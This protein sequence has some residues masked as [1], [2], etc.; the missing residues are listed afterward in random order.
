MKNIILLFVLISGFLNCKPQDLNNYEFSKKKD[1]FGSIEN[2]LICDYVCEYFVEHNYFPKSKNEYEKFVIE[3]Q[4]DEKI[5][6]LLKD[7]NYHF[8]LSDTSVVI[9]EYGHKKKDSLILYNIP[10]KNC[11]KLSR[12]RL[13]EFIVYSGGENVT[14]KSTETRE[15]IKKVLSTYIKKIRPNDEHLYLPKAT[16]EE[17]RLS[18]IIAKREDMKLWEVNISYSEHNRNDLNYL[19]RMIK[20]LLTINSI[21]S[22]GDIDL[23]R[24]PIMYYENDQLAPL[25]SINVGN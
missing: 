13:N 25:D 3:S 5:V 21:Q 19:V 11:K 15:Q 17:I 7:I 9:Y 2:V 14:R 24:I 8:Y 16:E 10:I 1:S 22:F 12:N 18:L 23:I 4:E 6:D 20:S